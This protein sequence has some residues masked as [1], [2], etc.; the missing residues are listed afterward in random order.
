MARGMNHVYLRGALA[1]D[2]E[3][4][5]VESSDKN[6]DGLAIIE[7]V[8][9]G[10]DVVMRDGREIRLPWYHRISILGNQANYLSERGMKQGDGVFVEGRLEYA[11]WQD[12][13]T[14]ENRSQVRVQG[15]RIDQMRDP[16][17]TVADAG[18][19]VRMTGGRNEVNL[20]GNLTRDPEF[21]TIANNDRL[22]KLGIAINESYRDRNG[23][24]VEKTHYID[25][26]LWRE[27]ADMAQELRRGDAVEVRGRLVNA[28]WQAQD[29]TK[30]HATRVEV[31]E[32]TPL[33]R[34]VPGE[35]AETATRS[36]GSSAQTT[37]RQPRAQAA[38]SAPRSAANSARSQRAPAKI[39]LDEGLQNLPEEE[40]LPF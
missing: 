36:T 23:N 32:I 20:I 17:E 18:G 1:R 40:D 16:V 28:S 39:D 38:A 22:A 4:R 21:Q 31:S 25:L 19:G 10:E 11:Q 7:F 15:M 26:T 14:Q 12:R 30:R 29:G 8:V 13:E 6:R 37:T 33:R 34:G 9:A 27:L 3:L 5:F 2:P 24:Q 35:M